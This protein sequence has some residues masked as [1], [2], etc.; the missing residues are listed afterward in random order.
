[1]KG[2]TDKSRSKLLVGFEPIACSFDRVGQAFAYLKF[3]CYSFVLKEENA[4]AA[5]SARFRS[6]ES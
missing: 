2:G 3:L 5:M 4:L 6:S 1:M